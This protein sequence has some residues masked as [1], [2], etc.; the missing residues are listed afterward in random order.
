MGRIGKDWWNPSAY[1]VLDGKHG[2]SQSG[3]GTTE[4]TTIAE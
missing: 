4:L 3:I 2:K 1:S